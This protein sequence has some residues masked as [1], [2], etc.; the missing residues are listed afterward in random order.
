MDTTAALKIQ[1]PGTD[2][3]L[4]GLHFQTLEA[5]LSSLLER[6]ALPLSGRPSTESENLTP[7]PSIAFEALRGVS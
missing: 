2:K 4:P 6:G 3:L 5:K 1:K 7:V